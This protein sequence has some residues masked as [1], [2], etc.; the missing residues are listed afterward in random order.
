[1]IS[2]LTGFGR[3]SFTDE[4][5]RISVELK[6]VN[7][8]FLQIDTHVPYGFNWSDGLLRKKINNKLS[9][10]KVWCHL[11]FV[12]FNPNQDVIINKPLLKKLLNLN[13]ELATDGSELP[14][15]LD[16]LLS[17]PGVMKMDSK[18][19]DNE[20]VWKRIEPVL[21]EALEN[22]VA[23]RTREGENLQKDLLIRKESIKEALTD[24][25]KRLPEFK[26]QFI[27][28]FSERIKELAQKADMDENRLNTEIAIWVD[29]TDVS[30]EITRLHSHLEEF[31]KILNTNKPVGRRLDFLVQELNREA[32][33]LGSKVS[34]IS[35]SQRIID[36]KCEIEKI[37]EQAQNIE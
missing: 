23:S 37:R 7:N 29:K 8:R 19:I 32:N 18:V 17:L 9:R 6:S 28:K 34:D 2:S 26:N 35:V 27:E 11:E 5:G 33:T 4:A 12:D 14:V 36:I 3:A 15:Q 13:N 21:D 16:G 22:L 30:E 25:E 24:I 10:G 31:Q 1:M 20:Q